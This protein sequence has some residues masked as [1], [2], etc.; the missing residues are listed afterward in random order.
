MVQFSAAQTN[1]SKAGDYSSAFD[2]FRSCHTLRCPTLHR[3]TC[4]LPRLH[5]YSTNQSRPAN[6]S[7]P[8]PALPR[9]GLDIH[10]VRVP[11][12]A[13]PAEPQPDVSV[14]VAPDPAMPRLPRL[15][16]A[17][18][19]ASH[20]CPYNPVLAAP[21]APRLPMLTK[22]LTPLWACSFLTIPAE[23]CLSTPD[24]TSTVITRSEHSMPVRIFPALPF[25]VPVGPRP[26][27]LVQSCHVPCRL[28]NR[29]QS[30]PR[31]HCPTN[32]R[33]CFCCQN[34]SCRACLSASGLDWPHDSW[35]SPLR[36]SP[37][38]PITPY[39]L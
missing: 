35:P 33:L 2:V 14:R 24:H 18:S 39:L 5:C 21:S 11:R 29:L 32:P 19:S 37:L 28:A 8:I 7:P 31:L 20:A 22:P 30:G 4:P 16:P 23:P 10:S 25:L 36:T 38:G 27:T 26:C 3:P 6:S 34:Q 13:L 1:C 9:R 12:L 17:F 15:T